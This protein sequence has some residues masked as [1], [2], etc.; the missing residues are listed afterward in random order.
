MILCSVKIASH[1]STICMILVHDTP[2][3]TSLI[4]PSTATSMPRNWY[5]GSSP[6]HTYGCHKP[7]R[8]HDRYTASILPGR[9]KPPL[10]LLMP[11]SVETDAWLRI[12]PHHDFQ[13]EVHPWSGDKDM[14]EPL[15][16]AAAARLQDGLAAG[17]RRQGRHV[18]RCLYLH[19]NV[20]SLV[21]L[22][23]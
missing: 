9:S 21:F 19:E 5:D 13:T 7:I 15:L 20:V 11:S 16:Q 2:I 8:I 4:W 10:S 1:T 3:V 14:E 23:P 18:A 17:G 6:P 12:T 22:T